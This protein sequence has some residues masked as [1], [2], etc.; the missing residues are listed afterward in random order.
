MTYVENNIKGRSV[1]QDCGSDYVTKYVCSS[2][3][4][5][6]KKPSLEVLGQ[7]DA[8]RDLALR[9]KTSFSHPWQQ[10]CSGT[11][12]KFTSVQR[13]GTGKKKNHN[14]IISIG[15]VVAEPSLYFSAPVL[16]SG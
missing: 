5:E 9:C 7:L 2:S 6:K 11:G 14:K 1:C 8:D 3:F 4:E 16:R 15:F 12:N 13:T 10:S